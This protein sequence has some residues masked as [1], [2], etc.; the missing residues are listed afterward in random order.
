MAVAPRERVR[1]KGQPFETLVR[2]IVG[3][4]ISVLAAEAVW[5]RL[6]S[7]V[8]CVEPEAVLRMALSQLRSAGLSQRKAE[9]VQDLAA[10]FQDGRIRTENWKNESDETIISELI[11]VRGIG[12]WTSEMFLIFHLLRPNVFPVDDLGLQ[13][14]LHLEYGCRYPVSSRRLDQFRQSFAPWN[15]VATWYLWRSLDPIPVAY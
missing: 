15:S 10:A 4:Q 8:D 9:Y 3:Q 14:A 13:K 5:Q 1:S 6:K 12:R 11:R 7:A 2:S